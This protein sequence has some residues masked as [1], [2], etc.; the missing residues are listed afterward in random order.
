M[1]A[2]HWDMMG[3]C[4]EGKRGEGKKSGKRGEK[5][6]NHCWNLNTKDLPHVYNPPKSE[7]WR[8]DLPHRR[9]SEHPVFSASRF[10]TLKSS[11]SL[12]CC[13]VCPV[14]NRFGEIRLASLNY[15]HPY[16]WEQ[17]KVL[18]TVVTF[19]STKVNLNFR[20]LG[21]SPFSHNAGLGSFVF[22]P[23]WFYSPDLRCHIG[24]MLQVPQWE[25]QPSTWEE[26]SH[27]HSC[28][29]AGCG[30]FNEVLCLCVCSCLCV[31]H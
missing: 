17:Y 25:V 29:D 14:C 9:E 30:A 6:Q 16:C 7:G 26:F 11:E 24:A 18:K 19:T 23:E 8:V 15:P 5:K 20:V 4:G 27:H 3:C 1:T 2:E 22:R 10:C 13:P 31:R 12:L 21:I 28:N